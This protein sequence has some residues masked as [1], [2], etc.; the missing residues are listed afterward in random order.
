MASIRA[1][2]E[3]FKDDPTELIDSEAV[4]RACREAKHR[5]RERTLDPLCTL[6]AFATQIV[7]GNTAMAHLVRIM[8][9]AGVEFTE[10][11][12]CQ[13]R[14]RLPVAVV[15]AALEAFI[16]RARAGRES[17]DG[18]WHGHR[19]ALIDGTDI[20]TP[21]TP[22]LRA[23]FGASNN[24]A[25]GAGLPIVHTLMLFDAR[26]GLLLGMHA[27]PAH[28]HDLRHAHDLHPA[29]EPGDV[30]VGDRGFA[31]YVHLHRLAKFGCHGV[32][33]VSASWKIPFP[34]RSGE[35]TRHTYNRHRRHEPVL[36]ELI[37]PD[38]QIIEILKPRNRPEHIT[39]EEFAEIPGK[40]VVR[41]VRFRIQG[42][43]VRTREVTLL[44][45]L[46]DAR[47]YPAK[48]LADLYRTRWRIEVNLRHLKRT[49]GM[50]RLK[51]QSVQ[52]VARE[53]L[54]FALVYNAVCHV[55][56]RAAREQGVEPDRLSFVDTLRAV[57]MSIHAAATRIADPPRLKHWPTR[58]HRTH[59]RQIKRLHS[60]FLV[61]TRPRRELVHWLARR[62]DGAI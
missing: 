25:P 39:P 50:D 19:T 54:M 34:A 48:A 29:L 33:R 10:S 21:D 18:L 30:L 61:M 13:A 3:Q 57:A 42:Q 46:I 36:V 51:C 12:Y 56:A 44:T 53:M 35:R 23:A 4:E 62:D 45:T 16:A 6:R 2:L 59:P 27:A 8:A 1:R 9:A 41:A 20:N 17:T 38:D 5:W 24:C 31:S 55:R 32:L 22:P 60:H 7:H 49:M 43:G 37:G 40:M 11:A 28:T 58:H 15:R 14:A 47:T 26:D 52:G